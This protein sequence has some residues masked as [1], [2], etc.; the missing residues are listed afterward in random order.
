MEPRFVLSVSFA[1]LRRCCGKPD[2]VSSNRKKTSPGIRENQRMTVHRGKLGVRSTLE[3]L[4]GFPFPVCNRVSS[5]TR[6]DDLA[7]TLT[8]RFSKYARFVETS[9]KKME[10]RKKKR[11]KRE[12]GKRERKG[13]NSMFLVSSSSLSISRS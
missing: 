10:E 4:R 8:R 11:E 3:E 9:R 13:E 2:T 7:E 5:S 1:G 6:V 12:G